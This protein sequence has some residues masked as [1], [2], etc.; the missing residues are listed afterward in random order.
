VPVSESSPPEALSGTAW[1]T[2]TVADV[3]AVSERDV[4]LSEACQPALI[5]KVVDLVSQCRY[6]RW[7][8]CILRVSP[9]PAVPLCVIGGN[10]HSR[11]TGSGG[12]GS[13]GGCSGPG[14]NDLDGACVCIA[15]GNVKGHAVSCP[16]DA[17]G[18]GIQ[19]EALAQTLRQKPSRK[20]GNIYRCPPRRRCSA[21]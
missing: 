5:V 6:W 4:A 18:P 17:I 10:L 3:P 21:R 8:R 12:E 1:L 14:G 16:D 7:C 9:G 11:D 13:R 20:P 2:T 15:W 19:G